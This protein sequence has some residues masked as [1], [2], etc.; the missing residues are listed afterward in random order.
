MA[1]SKRQLSFGGAHS[2]QRLSFAGWNGLTIQNP[3]L[4]TDSKNTWLLASALL[5][6]RI[7]RIYCTNS[8]SSIFPSAT[9]PFSESSSSKIAHRVS[10]PTMRPFSSNAVA[11]SIFDTFPL[12]SSESE[13]AHPSMRLNSARAPLSSLRFPSAAFNSCRGVGPAAAHRGHQRCGG[14]RWR[15][16]QGQR[17]QQRWQD[18]QKTEREGDL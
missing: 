14:E 7:P 2:V 17:E 5:N 8:V 16:R 4:L 9:V 13:L 1:D 10:S 12:A 3:K 6:A 15:R 11:R 18:S